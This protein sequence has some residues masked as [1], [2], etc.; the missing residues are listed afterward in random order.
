MQK[1]YRGTLFEL[2]PER[3]P[4]KKKSVAYMLDTE[5]QDKGC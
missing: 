1:A 5:R 3:S 4:H 2:A